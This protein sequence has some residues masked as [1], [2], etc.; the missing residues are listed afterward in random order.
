[1]S[2][3]VRLFLNDS[4]EVEYFSKHFDPADFQHEKLAQLTVEIRKR[5]TET[6]EDLNA[7]G[8][9]AKH[10]KLITEAYQKEVAD[11]IR[12]GLLPFQIQVL[13]KLERQRSAMHGARCLSFQF[14]LFV[15]DEIGLD[16]EKKSELGKEILELTTAYGEQR[17]SMLRDSIGKATNS[18]VN[19]DKLDAFLEWYHIWDRIDGASIKGRPGVVLGWRLEQ[20]DE[21]EKS[22]KQRFTISCTEEGLELTEYQI[23]EITERRTRSRNRRNPDDYVDPEYAR[24]ILS[25]GDGKLEDKKAEIRS[26]LKAEEEAEAELA[27]E[28]SREVLLPHQVGLIER[29]AKFD[30]QMYES[31][32][33]DEFGVVVGWLEI[34]GGMDESEKHHLKRSVESIRDEF[35]E[36]MQKVRDEYCSKVHRL[37]PGDAKQNFVEKF[38]E[39]YDLEGERVAR[40]NKARK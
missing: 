31:R 6:I 35:H 3:L 39:P 10:R 38:G 37:L 29:M 25:I 17:V 7:E 8:V 9:D 4:F 12:E 14:P 1:M 34:Q 5:W 40:W 19:I 18:E 28:I 24:I 16:A 32:F 13:S 20:F 21:Y 11:M 30:R 22:R 26:R 2:S 36:A 33:G 27:D 15:A 23:A